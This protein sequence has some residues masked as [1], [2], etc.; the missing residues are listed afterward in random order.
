MLVGACA[1]SI[2]DFDKTES[3]YHF[4]IKLRKYMLAKFAPFF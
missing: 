3:P 2:K 4:G 1:S